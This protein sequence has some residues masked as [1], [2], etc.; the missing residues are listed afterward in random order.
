MNSVFYELAMW[1]EKWCMDNLPPLP[2]TTW[3][4]PHYDPYEIDHS[5]Y[6]DITYDYNTYNQSFITNEVEYEHHPE[7]YYDM[8]SDDDFYEN[9]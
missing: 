3:V 4:S 9:T 5:H 2:I 7:P 6:K 1:Q 8:E